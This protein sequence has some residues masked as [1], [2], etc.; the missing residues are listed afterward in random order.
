MTL[1][2]IYLNRRGHDQNTRHWAYYR[3]TSLGGDVGDHIQVCL[4]AWPG[5]TDIDVVGEETKAPVV[6]PSDTGF[7]SAYPNLCSLLQNKW[8]ID[9]NQSVLIGMRAR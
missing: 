7:T 4:L 8:N 6:N 3:V 1:D 2:S 5:L 9:H